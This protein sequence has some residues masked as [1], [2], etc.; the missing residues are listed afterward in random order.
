[1]P[2]FCLMVVGKQSSDEAS[3]GLYRW[4]SGLASVLASG[5]ASRLSSRWG[6]INH[7]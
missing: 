4:L 1:M 6:R 2:A 7:W 3:W 5:L